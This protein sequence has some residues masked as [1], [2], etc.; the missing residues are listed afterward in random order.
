MRE[1]ETQREIAREACQHNYQSSV[2]KWL[3][4]KLVSCLF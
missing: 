2:C 4:G 3:R 1:R